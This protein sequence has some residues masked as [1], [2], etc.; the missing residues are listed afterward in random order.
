MEDCII[1]QMGGGE[2]V[3]QHAQGPGFSLAPHKLAVVAHAYN[4]SLSWRKLGE[5]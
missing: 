2:C 5:G 4:P 1:R 3:T